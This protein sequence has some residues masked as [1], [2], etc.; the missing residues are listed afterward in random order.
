MKIEMNMNKTKVII[1]VN[2]QQDIQQNKEIQYKDMILKRLMKYEYMGRML[3]EAGKIE[4]EL[5]D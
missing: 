1:T 4:V 5:R 2:C 3:T